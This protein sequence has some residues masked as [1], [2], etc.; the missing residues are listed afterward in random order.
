MRVLAVDPGEK[1]IG[2]AISDPSGTVARPL[3]VIRH[4][5]RQQ[6]AAAIA[7]LAADHE[8]GRIVVGQAMGEDDQVTFE[9][10]RAARLAAAIRLHTQLPVE[11]WD[12]SLTTSDARAARAAMGRS[13][14]RRGDHLDDLAAAILLQSYLEAKAAARPASPARDETESEKG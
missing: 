6:D 9:G 8:A 2:I 10:R 11:L 4:V 12:E 14:R 5:S 13:P 3:A 1:R 7:A